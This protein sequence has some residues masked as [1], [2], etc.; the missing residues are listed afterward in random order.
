MSEP[1]RIG[2]VGCGSVMQRPYTRQINQLKLRNR[3]ETVVACDVKEECREIVLGEG[4]GYQ[5]FT[6]DFEE[7]VDAEDVDL[8]LITTSMQEHGMITRA[9]LEAGKH[10]LVEKPMSTS[11]GEAAELVELA[12]R[13]PGFLVPAP[14]VILSPTYQRMWRHIHNGDIGQPYLARAFYGWAGPDWGQW[15]YKPGGGSMFDLG[16]YNV[17]SL[18]GFLGPAKRVTG[19]VGTAIPERMVEGEM[20]QVET[21]D[22]AHICI[23]FA[24]TC[25]AVITTGFTIQKYRTPAIELY[26][27]QGTIQ[28]MGDDW[29]PDGYELWQNSVGAWQIFE[30]SAPGWPW[31]DGIRHLVE[32]INSD[33]EPIIQPEHAYHV[34]EI[35]EK[36]RLAGR[37]GQARTIESTFTPPSFRADEEGEAVH[38]RH[39]RTHS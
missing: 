18:T 25:Y 27:S 4:F 37:D 32:C 2:V 15:F 31:T 3:V 38:L 8:V 30:E 1:V 20:T 22:N 19:L 23:E 17:V 33:T 11:L 6:T 29:N 26:G 9:A 13:S 39:D 12:K 36:A 14:H 28:M 10:V 34:I 5:R 16:V 35:I 24:N 21:D 7:V